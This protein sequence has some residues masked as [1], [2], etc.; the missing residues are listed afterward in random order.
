[1]AQLLGLHLAS[2]LL[3]KSQLKETTQGKKLYAKDD[4]IFQSMIS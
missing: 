3:A 4:L 2:F 1:V